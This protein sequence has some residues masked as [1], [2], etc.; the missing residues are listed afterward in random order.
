MF[1]LVEDD[2]I[3]GY[4]QMDTP[5]VLNDI[6]YPMNWLRLAPAYDRHALGI[7]DVVTSHD[8]VHFDDRFYWQGNT[9]ESVDNENKIVNR[10]IKGIAK[11]LNQLKLNWTTA[12]KQSVNA[13][14]NE[15]DWYVVRKAENGTE[16]PEAVAEY[17]SAMRQKSNDLEKQ[18]NDVTTVPDLMDIVLKITWPKRKDL[19]ELT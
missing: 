10:V 17:R 1:A 19:P 15:T 18:I 12:I 4:F 7:Y 14:L 16:L 2:K 9:V 11:D 5:F 3:I 8:P 6:Q 13:M